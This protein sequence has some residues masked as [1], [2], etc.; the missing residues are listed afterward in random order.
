MMLQRPRAYALKLRLLASAAAGPRQA[1]WM[2]LL[3]AWFWLKKAAGRRGG[4]LHHITVA[5]DGRPLRIAVGEYTDLEVVRE[6]FAS[7]VY[8]LPE[9]LAP[10]VILDV[11]SNIGASVKFLRARYPDAEI[12]AIEPDPTA[13]IT[14]RANTGDDPRTTVHAVAVGGR[15]ER[16]PFY[17]SHHGWASSFSGDRRAAGGRW[18]VVDV[19]SLEDLLRR[20]GHDRVDLIKMDIEGAEW[21]VFATTRL[22]DHADVVLGELHDQDDHAPS[23]Y[24]PGLDGL[25][26]TYTDA[27]HNSAFLATVI[28]R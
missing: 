2:V 7:G 20:V 18:T 25:H 17:Q 4:R 9:T 27:P 5:H 15:T 6:V 26:L 19:L 1:A 13:L 16:K 21:D 23:D 24:S 3:T 12:H 8:T 11:G 14:L 28:R 10:A 22:G